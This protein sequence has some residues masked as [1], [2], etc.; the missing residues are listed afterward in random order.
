MEQSLSVLFF[1]TFDMD[2]VVCRL[3]C[4]MAVGTGYSPS[5]PDLWAEE[6]TQ[7]LPCFVLRSRADI[8]AA[9]EE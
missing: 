7:Y 8:T 4:I 5:L 2:L 9:D 3:L 1:V 6:S